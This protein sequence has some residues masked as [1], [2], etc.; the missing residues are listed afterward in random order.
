MVLRIISV[1]AVDLHRVTDK[2]QTNAEVEHQHAVGALRDVTDLAEAGFPDPDHVQGVVHKLETTIALKLTGMILMI[3]MY[4]ELFTVFPGQRQLQLYQM[5]DPDGKT[6]ILMKLRVKLPYRNVADVMEVKVDDGAE[7]NILPLNTFRSMFPK[8]WMRMATQKKMPS[9][10]Q[11]Q[12]SNAM[13]MA[14]W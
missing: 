3:S 1:H 10:D 13:T 5:T 2:A 11:R 6:K 8:N 12:H 9:E 7:A 14:S 4:L